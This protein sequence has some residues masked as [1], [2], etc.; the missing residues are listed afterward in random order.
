M[1]V[2]APLRR[3]LLLH[4]DPA[5]AR[6][7]RALLEPSAE[8]HH[9]VAHYT[10]LNDALTCLQIDDADLIVVGPEPADVDQQRAVR[11]LGAAR[12]ETPQL[13]RLASPEPDQVAAL[14]AAGAREILPLDEA[15][16]TA[17]LRTMDFCLR[18]GPI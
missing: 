16:L 7:V 2:E 12:P 6:R 11:E 3:L 14:R 17:W 15:D 18:E 8:I 10:H 4:R 13:A 1:P 5:L 9:R